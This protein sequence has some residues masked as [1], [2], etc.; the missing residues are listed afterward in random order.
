[1]PALRDA[2]LGVRHHHTLDGS[3]YPDA[4]EARRFRWRPGS[5]PLRCLFGITRAA[6]TAALSH[7]DAIAA[8]DNAAGESFDPAVLAALKRSLAPDRTTSQPDSNT[9][10]SAGTTGR[11]DAFSACGARKRP[12][13][14][15]M[16]LAPFSRT[17]QPFNI[18]T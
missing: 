14:G 6:H 15:T 18:A 7:D 12:R 2:A 4:L 3:G 1:M 11:R 8:L 9:P 17:G 10:G 13:H 16:P 5:S